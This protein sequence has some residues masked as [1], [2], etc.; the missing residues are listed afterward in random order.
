MNLS[1]KELNDLYYCIGKTIKSTE[2]KLITDAELE[3]LL[4]KVNDEIMRIIKSEE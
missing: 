4:D 3:V 1:L 2:T